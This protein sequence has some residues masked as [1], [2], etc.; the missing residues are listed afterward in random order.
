VNEKI[1]LVITIDSLSIV[2]KGVI[3]SARG[4]VSYWLINLAIAGVLGVI[5]GYINGFLKNGFDL[6]WIIQDVLGLS[7]IYFKKFTL[8]EQEQ[9]IFARLTPGY[10]F[11]WAKNGS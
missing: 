6:N 10:N 2:I 5:K 4:N 9:L 8:V 1:K 7:F 3:D 11:T